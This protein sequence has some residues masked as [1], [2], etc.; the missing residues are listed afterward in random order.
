MIKKFSLFISFL[1]F[2]G[3]LYAQ[4]TPPTLGPGEH[5]TNIWSL[6]YDYQT[7]GSVRYLVQ[8]PSNPANLCATQMA[9]HDSVSPAGTNRYVWY[10]YSSD[11]GLTWDNGVEIATSFFQGFHSLTVRNGAPLV[12]LHETATPT[13][14]FVY[15]DATWGAGSF[16]AIGLFPQTPLP[17]IW[18]HVA[19][20]TN[21]NIIVAAAPNPGFACNYS[22]WNGSAWSA[23]TELQNTGGPSGNFSVEAGPGGLAYIHGVDYNSTFTAGNRL[24]TSN[25]NG[26]SFTLQTGSSAPPEMIFETDDTLMAFIDGGRTGIYVGNEVHLVYTV[27]ANSSVQLPTPPNTVWFK[28][29]KILHWS[30]AT[31]VDTVAARF[32]MPNMADT[33]THALVTPVC[34]PSLGIYNG[35]LYCTFTAFLRGNT[36]TVDDGSI[37]NA[38]EIFITYSTDNGNTWST[39]VNI[40]LTPNVEEKHSSVI[41]NLV[42]PPNDS[43]GVF[44]LKDMKAGGWVNVPGWGPAPVYGIYKKLSGVI[45]IKQDLEIVREFKLF[46][47]YPNPFN[48]TTTISYYIPKSSNVTLKVYNILGSEVATLVNGFEKSGAKEIVFD[49]SHLAS[50]IYYYT[51]AAGEYRDTKKMV[52]VK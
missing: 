46:Q 30:S 25:N 52:V 51:I 22:Y 44:Y 4:V 40:T 41:R 36:Q 15:E 18:P 47:N 32:N 29:C 7:N 34:Q 19:V 14:T 8:D 5:W 35:V 50:G 10:S 21:G 13:R 9:T 24:W 27:Y 20:S 45:G 23:H 28:K 42:T 16:T 11:A 31:G 3:I 49:A 48:P 2:A 43:V 38:G 26:A 6:S 1:L 33:I 17:I 39:P 37:V 12:A